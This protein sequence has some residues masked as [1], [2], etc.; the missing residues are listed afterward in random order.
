MVVGCSKFNVICLV[1]VASSLARISLVRRLAFYECRFL[2]YYITSALFLNM[3]RLAVFM[4][5]HRNVTLGNLQNLVGG[6]KVLAL[7]GSRFVLV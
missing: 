7:M 3:F 6:G 1:L 2:E 5:I 4:H